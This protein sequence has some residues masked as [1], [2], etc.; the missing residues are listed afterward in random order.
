MSRLRL[1]DLVLA[2]WPGRK[3]IFYEPILR[4]STA[5]LIDN[6]ADYY[7]RGTDREEWG[8]ADFPCIAPPAPTTWFEFPLPSLVRRAEMG[9]ISSPGASRGSVGFLLTATDLTEDHS[10]EHIDGVKAFFGGADNEMAFDPKRIRGH[11]EPLQDPRERHF[12]SGA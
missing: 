12:R 1:L 9:D 7:Y 3:R 6:V 11:A 10:A 4:S 8:A 5:F 2:Q